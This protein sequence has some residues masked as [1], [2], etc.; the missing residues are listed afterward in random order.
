MN[1]QSTFHVSVGEY[2]TGMTLRDY[3]AAKAM[4]QVTFRRQTYANET[5]ISD[6]DADFCYEIAD[7]MIKASK[8]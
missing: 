7:A 4:D 2:I 6:E 3:F 1:N 8:K 5:R